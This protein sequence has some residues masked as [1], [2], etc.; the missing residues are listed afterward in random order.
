[1]SAP[2]LWRAVSCACVLLGIPWASA[3][4]HPASVPAVG[5]PLTHQAKTQVEIQVDEPWARASLPGQKVS[6]AYMQLQAQESGLVLLGARS[7]L[8]ANVQIHTMQ[9]E[10][11][12]MRMR[13][14][15]S[16]ALPQGQKL[17]LAAG[18]VH[19]MLMGLTQPLLAGQELPLELL[20]S[21]GRSLNLSLPVRAAVPAA[22]SPSKA[23]H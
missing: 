17:E 4:A 16:L 15:P 2:S 6:A 10:G 1:M 11:D 22:A 3:V 5:A 12:V 7:P 13:P 20:F 19:I 8:A 21:H 14:L 23:A 18:G 9:M